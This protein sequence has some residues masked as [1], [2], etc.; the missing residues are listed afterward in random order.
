M[1]RVRPA[2]SFQDP[3]VSNTPPPTSLTSCTSAAIADSFRVSPGRI[4][5]TTFFSSACKPRLVTLPAGS[6]A[7][8]SPNSAKVDTDANRRPEYEQAP[9]TTPFSVPTN[10]TV[11][12]S[13]SSAAAIEGGGAEEE[14]GEGGEGAEGGDG[15][16]SA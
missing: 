3:S 10:L 12:A 6:T 2:G 14:G 1:P 11:G 8:V 7:P 13:A 4:S 15:Q 16:Q 5:R 9:S